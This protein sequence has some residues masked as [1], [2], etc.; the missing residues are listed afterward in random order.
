MQ[1]NVEISRVALYLLA[2]VLPLC[3]LILGLIIGEAIGLA[4]AA[5]EKHLGLYSDEDEQEDWLDL[6]KELN[7]DED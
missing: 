4:R 7:E 2:I 3:A 1:E 6:W 5:R